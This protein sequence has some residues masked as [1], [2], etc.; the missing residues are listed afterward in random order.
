MEGEREGGKEYDGEKI[1]CVMT[2]YVPSRYNWVCCGWGFL[3]MQFLTHSCCWHV[4]LAECKQSLL[5][6]WLSARL[7]G[8]VA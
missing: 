7:G 8:Q 6:L 3:G 5:R 2:V 1:K 4:V